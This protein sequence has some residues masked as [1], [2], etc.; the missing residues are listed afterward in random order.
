LITLDA[1]QLDDKAGKAQMFSSRAR[2]MIHIQ[3]ASGMPHQCSKR[4]S[5][6]SKALATR[7]EL[8]V[9]LLLIKVY[10]GQHHWR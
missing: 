8:C 4:P 3:K 1:D 5:Q 7:G 9:S 2:L 10:G 6:F